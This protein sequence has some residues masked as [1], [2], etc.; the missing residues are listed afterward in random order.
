MPI[1]ALVLEL[2]VFNGILIAFL[3]YQYFDADRALKKTRAAEKA[4]AEA[5][6]TLVND[7]G[8]AS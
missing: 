6:K 7:G 1:T 5:P 4:K 2:V 3:I 8:E